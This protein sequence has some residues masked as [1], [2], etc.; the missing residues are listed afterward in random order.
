MRK[1]K[2][3]KVARKDFPPNQDKDLP[4]STMEG[5]STNNNN[6]L[7]GETDTTSPQFDDDTTNEEEGQRSEENEESE[8][9]I[10]D[11]PGQE[12]FRDEGAEYFSDGIESDFGDDVSLNHGLEPTDF[13]ESLHVS[14]L[15][16]EENLPPEPTPVGTTP[17]K[18]GENE[19]KGGMNTTDLLV[20]GGVGIG[21]IAG[22]A[23]FSTKM[24]N[25]LDKS[26]DVDEDDAAAI[27]LQQQREQSAPQTGESSANASSG[28]IAGSAPVYVFGLG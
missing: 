9:E 13:S 5:S 20:A 11:D 17:G 25:L 4:I 12:D 27:V 23:L 21:A 26:N 28:N 15:I 18:D 6:S 14:D 1:N 8:P 10:E 24:K 16:S 2:A 22:V 3:C 19:K 7:T